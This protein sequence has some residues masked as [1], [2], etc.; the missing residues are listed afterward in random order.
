MSMKCSDGHVR[1]RGRRRRRPGNGGLTGT[2]RARLEAVEVLHGDV[3]VWRRT[4][5]EWD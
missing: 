3:R 5:L 2:N 4:G 1:D